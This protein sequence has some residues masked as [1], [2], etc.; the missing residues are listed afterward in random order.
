[1]IIGITGTDGAGKGMAVEHL[2][3][4]YGCIHCSARAMLT[5]EILRRGL[6][7]D[8]ANMR[9]VANDLR[10]LH[11]NDYVVTHFL[12]QHAQTES[13]VVIESIRALAEVETLKQEGGILLAVDADQT[14]RFDRIMSRKSDSDQI[15]FAEFVEHEALE[16]NDPDPNGMQKAAVMQAADCIITNNGTLAE[17]NAAVDAFIERH[18]V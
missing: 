5:E 1:M 18:I 10:K 7:V 15:T 16:M 13:N 3:A 8:R 12:A 2:V 14:L 11:G 17:L 9:L 4:R 6:S